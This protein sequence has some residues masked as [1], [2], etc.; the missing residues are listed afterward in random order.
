MLVPRVSRSDGSMRRLTRTTFVPGL[1]RCRELR[2]FVSDHLQGVAAREDAIQEEVQCSRRNRTRSVGNERTPSAL[3]VEQ[4]I[5]SQHVQRFAHGDAAN[6]ELHRKLFLASDWRARWQGSSKDACLKDIGDLEVQRHRRRGLDEPR[7]VHDRQATHACLLY[8]GVSHLGNHEAVDYH[9]KVSRGRPA[10][11]QDMVLE[12]DP[13]ETGFAGPQPIPLY[14]QIVNVL[15]SRILSGQ[16]APGALLG[17]EKDFGS[18]FAVSRITVTRALNALES[19]GLITRKRALGTFVAPGVRPRGRIEL[20][21]SLDAVILMGQ[22]GET[23]EV[24]Y[25]E[26]PASSTVASRLDMRDGS[27]VTRVRRL[28]ANNGA[29]NTFVVDYLPLDIGRRFDANSLRTHSLVHLLD[30]EPDLRLRSG[31]QLMSARSAPR[32]LARKFDVAVGTPILLVERDLQ[33]VAGRTVA[34]SQFHYL[35]HPQFVRVSR[36]GR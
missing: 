1:R 30:Q 34:Y 11:A 23:R 26:V 36:V 6:A 18:E 4:T 20:H 33:N 3:D 5:R 15:E 7:R 9:R 25:D 12:P 8:P 32:D 31:H 24:E 35:G 28:R 21:G 2:L 10:R 17:T 27:R 14:L 13:V 16:C 19:K 29:L 22:L